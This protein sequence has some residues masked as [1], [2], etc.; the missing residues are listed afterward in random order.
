MKC[1]VHVELRPDILDPQG[2]AILHALQ[3]LGY[4]EVQD[5]RLAKT[6]QLVLNGDDKIALEARVKAMAEQLLANPVIENFR[7]EWPA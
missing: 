1:H 6:I 2:K 5:A 4:S 7:I 3:A